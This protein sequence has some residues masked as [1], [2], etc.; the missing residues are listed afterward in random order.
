MK[1]EEIVR[2]LRC[3]STPGGLSEDCQGCPYYRKEQLGAELKERL[4]ADTWP[5]CD[6]DKVGMDAADLIEHLA[7][8]NTALRKKV[9]QWVN[10]KDGL[11]K[12]NDEYGWVHCIATVSESHSSPFDDPFEREF[13]STALFDSEQKIWHIGHYES[14]ELAVNALID[15]DNSFGISYCVTHWMPLPE[16]AEE[17]DHHEPET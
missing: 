11:P 3:A 1:P 6:T 12:A 8:E 13:V 9:P 5:S 2:T 15:I 14:A 17:G 16:A 4:G 7:A 10:V